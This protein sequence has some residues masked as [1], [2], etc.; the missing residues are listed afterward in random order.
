MA[1]K[2]KAEVQLTVDDRSF[3]Q[4]L[5]DA[6]KRWGKFGKGFGKGIGGGFGR[7]IGGGAKGAAKLAGIAGFAGA[8]ALVGSEISKTM[9][10]EESLTRLG[11]ASRGALG[12]LNQFRSKVFAV[13]NETGLAREEVL[14][15]ASAYV[16]LTGDAKGAAASMELFAKIQRGTG[17]SMDDIAS[18]AAAMAQNLKIDPKDFERAFSILIAGGKAGS[19]ELK[20]MASLMAELAPLAE[21]FKGG[22]GTGGLANLGAALQLTRQGFGSASEAATGLQALMGSITKKADRFKGVKIFDKDPKTGKKTLRNFQQIIEDIGNSKLAKDPQALTKALGSKEAYSAFVQLTK[23]KGAWTDLAHSTENATDVSRDYEAYQN[24]A[25]G[26]MQKLWN[27]VK[28]QIAAALT[29]ER[30]EAFIQGIS[31]T[32]EVASALVGV[33]SDVG[34]AVVKILDVTGATM[35]EGKNDLAS[36]VA[37][38]EMSLDEVERQA[39]EQ[40]ALGSL[41]RST[42]AAKAERKR[43]AHEWSEQRAKQLQ[44]MGRERA[45][46][47]MTPMERDAAAVAADRARNA[48]APGSGVLQVN[49]GVKKGHLTAGIENDPSQLVGVAP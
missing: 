14:A 12:S 15:G 25:A 38:G 44:N 49:V 23:V 48:P 2:K 35:D 17:A 36:K 20:D 11:I 19:V 3:K 21:Q 29:P 39:N 28:N 13:S 22:G 27:G 26:R 18:S 47:K 16:T 7:V 34:N 37:R 6:S 33:L 41:V 40:G 30:I 9:Q 8:G 31:K 42:I 45:A 4:K 46:N 24:S 32:I 5:A 10:F 1:S 43:K